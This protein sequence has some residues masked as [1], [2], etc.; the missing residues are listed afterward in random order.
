[1]DN[2]A[3]QNTYYD[4]N[5]NLAIESDWFPGSLPENVFLDNMSY[6]DSA[7]SF[8]GFHSGKKKSFFLGYASGNYGRSNFMGGENC[9]I[10]IGKFVVLQGTNII[11]NKSVFIKDHCMFSW[12]SVIT[13]SWLH[14]EASSAE[15]RRKMLI[16][17][18]NDKNR[19]LEFPHPKQVRIEE[20]VWVGF[21][22]VILPGVT[23][24]RG[25]VIGSNSVIDKDV[26]PYAVVAGNP[27]KLIRFLEP[28]DTEVVKQEALKELIK[29]EYKIK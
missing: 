24:G 23:L 8:T 19:Y 28:N 15:A 11:S 6:P 9:E 20:N 12:G 1:M 5:G 26:P 2:P 3:A 25:C 27:Q 17:A 29:T 16:Q 13:D 10:N 18:A 4:S 7:F 21:K 22:A 14:I